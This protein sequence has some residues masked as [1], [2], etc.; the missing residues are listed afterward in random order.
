VERNATSVTTAL[1]RLAA[2]ATAVTLLASCNDYPVHRLLDSFEVRVTD[3]L[4][5]DKPVKLDFL[6]V[7]DQSASMCQEQRALSS[8]FQGFIKELGKLGAIDA[9]MAVVTAQQAPDKTAIKVVGRFMKTPAT[10]FPPNCME[11]VRMPCIT[12]GQ[13]KAPF[14]FTFPKSTDSS[15]CANKTITTT[16]AMKDSGTGKSIGSWNCKSP[17]VASHVA[18]LNCSVNSYCE[19]RCNPKNGDKDCEIFNK[20]DDSQKAECK[21][22][23]GGTNSDS[24]GCMFPPDTKSCPKPSELPD[25][26]QQA[27]LSKYFGCIATVGAAQTP[28]SKF[29]GGFRSAW[30]ALDKTGPNCDYDA[31]IKSLRRC[32]LDGGKWCEKDKSGT[33]SNGKCAS[34]IKSLCE[35][36]KDKK[37]CQ[38]TRLLRPDAYLVIVFISDDDDCSMKLGLNPLD[39]SVITKEVWEDCQIHGDALG[40]NQALNEGNCEFKREKLKLSYAAAKTPEAKAK[41]ANLW[42]PSDCEPGSISKTHAGLLKCPLGCKVVCDY[43]CVRLSAPRNKDGT[44]KSAKQL[45][46]YVAAVKKDVDT[47][48]TSC[49][50]HCRSDSKE[51]NACLENAIED[52]KSKIK[53]DKVFA[54]VDDY[55]TLFKGLKDD[56]AKVIVGAISGDTVVTNKRQ[57]HRDRVNYYRSQLKDQGP[58]Q[59]PY[60]CAGARGESNYGG[61]YIAL[62]DAFRENGRF[63]NVCEGKDFG[64]ALVGIAGTILQR[65]TKICLPQPPFSDAKTNEP[66]MKVTRKRDGTASVLKYNDG[67]DETK[68]NTFCIKPDNDCRAG[69]ANLIGLN[70]KCAV[71]R[72]CTAGLTCIDGICQVYSEAIFF[73]VVQEPGDEIEVNYG[74]DLGL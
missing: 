10:A 31:C 35:P 13:C 36:L 41:V 49:P 65:V 3:R 23:G 18:N 27:D 28:E 32:C 56:P 15:M 34:E 30:F 51:R 20:K 74:A 2:L 63:Y 9:Q 47:D 45:D 5:Q 48:Y 62:T 14:K 64:P 1:A 55:V 61:R 52:M 73:P 71:T 70:S 53:S 12:T 67:C 50:L 25:I 66:I 6:W 26:V 33:A 11:R 19:S 37:N 68:P 7:I 42:C 54:P 43:D 38:A 22:P 24:A 29:E 72:D 17:P 46:D 8:A 44:S 59:A 21:I 57:Q 39:K 16:P 69:K 58:G 4:S 40:S 60:I